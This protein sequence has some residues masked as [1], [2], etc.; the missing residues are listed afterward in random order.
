MI[1]F[2]GPS[3]TVHKSVE[4]IEV[5]GVLVDTTGSTETSMLHRRRLA[6]K[7]FWRNS[8]LLLRPGEYHP[9]IQAW[10]SGTTPY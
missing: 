10:V 3:V 8:K 9:K 6:G 5:L 2:N 7:T 1:T 4:Q